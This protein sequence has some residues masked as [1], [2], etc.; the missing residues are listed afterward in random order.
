MVVTSNENVFVRVNSALCSLLG[1][2]KQELLGRTV[3]D[4]THPDDWAES[5]KRLRKMRSGGDPIRRFEKRFR[6]KSGKTIWTDVSVR[7]VC[8]KRGKPQYTIGHIVDITERKRGEEEL[9]LANERFRVALDGSPTTAFTQDREFRYTWVYNPVS[10]VKPEDFLG[11]TD[12]DMFNSYEAQH[13]M[14][15]KRQVMKTGV[16]RRDEIVV[17]AGDDEKVFDA[18]YEPLRDERGTITGVIC[19]AVDITE[20]KRLEESLAEAN[21]QLK[22]ANDGLEQKVRDRTARLRK[23]TAELLLAEH[24]E[25]RRIAHVLHETLQQHLCGMK[26]RASHLKEGSSEPATIGL[27]DRLINEMDQ[28]ILLTRTLTTDLHPPVL[29]HLGIKA[30]IEWLA[31]DVVNKLGLKV[32]LTVDRGFTVPSDGKHPFTF[33]S[34]EIRIFTFEAVREL[35][36]N[37]VKHAKVK[38]AV[39]RLSPMGKGWVTVQVKDKGAGFDP[40]QQK[41]ANNHFGLFSIQERAESFGGRFEVTSLPGKGTCAT[42]ILPRK[43]SR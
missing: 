25:R 30:G 19:A 42:L 23:L 28:A 35:L 38:T 21:E 5:L 34:D 20:R 17:H 29:R 18:I 11:K 41:P 33:K 31:T 26:F 36:L 40:N 4:V 14:R 22:A 39:V 15:I 12:S 16:G 32:Q 9:R 1:Y 24:Q 13:L 37:A 6:H 27:A 2:S 7:M 10:P 8:D 3:R 43:E